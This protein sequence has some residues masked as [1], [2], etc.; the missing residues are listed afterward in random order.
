ML[1]IPDDNANKQ[2]FT[3]YLSE[4]K[5]LQYFTNFFALLIKL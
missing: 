1:G 2:I 5:I 4:S 3:I